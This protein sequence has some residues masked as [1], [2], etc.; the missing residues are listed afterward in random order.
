MG[1]NKNLA[2]MSSIEEVLDIDLND[3]VSKAVRE[4]IADLEQVI[5]YQNKT[6]SEKAKEIQT[7]KSNIDANN[8]DAAVFSELRSRYAAFKTTFDQKGDVDICIGKH[9]FLMIANIL[10]LAY[11]KNPS[12][13]GWY[14]WRSGSLAG[15]LAANFHHCKNELCAVVRAVSPNH[16]ELVP[17]LSRFVMPWDYP[18]ERVVKFLKD[19]PYNTNGC[20]FGIHEYWVNEGIGVKNMPW[21]FIMQSPHILEDDVFELFIEAISGKPYRK[22]ESY[23]LFALPKFNKNVTK[24][25]IDRMAEVALAYSHQELKMDQVIA[26]VKNGLS[27]FSTEIVEK[28]FAKAEGVPEYSIL[29]WQWFPVE[30]QKRFLKQKPI[31]EVWQILNSYNCQWK[32]EDKFSFMEEY[33]KESAV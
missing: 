8:A 22:S 29:S 11:N 5:K 20:M 13:A 28:F 1:R 12:G 16:A 25:Q 33:F 10:E 9:Q 2:K 23:L 3:V 15:N 14:G 24:S 27:S 31:K 4:K 19:L 17:M 32:D 18:K 26:F 21:D 7:L 30:Y 6:I